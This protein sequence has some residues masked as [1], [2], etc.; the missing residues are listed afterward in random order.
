MKFIADNM[1][2]SFSRWLRILGCE[3]KYYNNSSDNELLYITEEEGRILLTRDLELFRR[4]KSRELDAFF[5]EGVTKAERLAKISQRFNINLTINF[6]ISRCP[7]CNSL[8]KKVEK[9]EVLDKIS[10]GTLKHYDD[11]W[12]CIDCGKVY[13]RGSHWKNIIATITKAKKLLEMY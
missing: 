10:S 6:S 8:L 1:L 3:V 5:V 11:F 2:G 9:T 12:V 7:I 4:A 13:W